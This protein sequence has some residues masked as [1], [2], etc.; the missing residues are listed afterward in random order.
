MSG[1]LL[2]AI[3]PT[4]RVFTC[5]PAAHVPFARYLN[6]ER[7][8]D[9]RID[10]TLPQDRLPTAEPSHRAAMSLDLG[11][12][13]LALHREHAPA[14]RSERQ[15]PFGQPIQRGY[16][17]GRHHV[18]WFHVKHRRPGRD[19]LGAGP[20]DLDPAVQTKIKCH[21]L[22]EGGTP[23]QRLHQHDSDACAHDCQY[24]AGQ[25]GTRTN[26]HHIIFSTE[27]RCHRSAVQN[28]PIPDAWRLARADEPTDDTLGREQLRVRFGA[29]E[30]CP[31]QA[32]RRGSEFVRQRG[33][34]L[35]H[36]QTLPT[37]GQPTASRL[38]VPLAHGVRKIGRTG[39]ETSDART[40]RPGHHDQNEVTRGVRRPGAAAPRPRNRSRHRPPR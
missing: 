36:P 15:A 11:P 39:P 21:L 30:A 13:T 25:T 19:L 32:F 8:R 38:A 29:I 3:P 7:R 31:E 28:V 2:L 10:G 12:G 33:G 17:P 16:R 23:G 40:Y 6:H 35:R 24:N 27:Q 34:R 14:D 22:Q 5:R 18:G 37:S 9:S 20:D 1:T 4:R 26:I